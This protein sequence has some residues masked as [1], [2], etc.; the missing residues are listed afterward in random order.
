M[1]LNF[2]IALLIISGS[3]AAQNLYSG[4]AGSG[5]IYLKPLSGTS[6]S[7]LKRGSYVGPHILGDSVTSL[8][9]NF[10]REYVYYKPTYG[11]Y[12]VEEK[13]IMKHT[14]YKKVH[15]FDKYIIKAYL[16]DPSAKQEVTTRLVAV[17]NR[18]IKLLNFDTNQVEKEIKKLEPP[19][20]EKYL[21]GLQFR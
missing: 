2:I 13:V 3:G 6:P 10:E 15:D 21:L 12:A 5:V 11:A 8:L 7:N 1:R 16:S 14:I 9:N 17:I 20:F 18:G 4:G 19:D